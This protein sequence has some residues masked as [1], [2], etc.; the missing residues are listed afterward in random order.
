[1]D[2]IPEKRRWI[3][4]ISHPTAFAMAKGGAAGHRTSEPFPMPPEGNFQWFSMF[5]SAGMPA[6]R[7]F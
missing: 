2:R 1:M 6:V 4:V 3:S 7:H 5:H